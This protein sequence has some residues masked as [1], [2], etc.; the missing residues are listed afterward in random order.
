MFE[1]SKGHGERQP[2]LSRGSN[3][4]PEE[5]EKVSKSYHKVQERQRVGVCAFHRGHASAQ[6]PRE[7]SLGRAQKHYI[8]KLA[9]QTRQCA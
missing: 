3:L 8:I 4:L 2:H 9:E 7:E 6:I 5:I 1:D